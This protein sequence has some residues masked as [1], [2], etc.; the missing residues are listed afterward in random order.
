MKP[1]SAFISNSGIDAMRPFASV[2]K[3]SKS[4]LKVLAATPLERYAMLIADNWECCNSRHGRTKDDFAATTVL[5]RQPKEAFCFDEKEPA[6]LRKTLLLCFNPML[7]N[8][9]KLHIA[10]YSFFNYNDNEALHISEKESTQLR[11]ILKIIATEQQHDLDSTSIDLLSHL[12]AAALDNCRRFYTRQFIMRTDANQQTIKALKEII[13]HYYANTNRSF[14]PTP[15]PKTAYIAEQ[16]NLSKQY[17]EDLI[18]HETGQNID[19]HIKQ[20]RVEI[21]EK[22][23]QQTDKNTQTIARQLGFCSQNCLNS[24]IEKTHGISAEV[25]RMAN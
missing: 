10:D 11:N 5:F 14:S 6:R 20:C 8:E 23:L 24:I 3:L 15:Q 1:V 2:D 12:V 4:D 19:Q 16:L 18:H 21:A 17:L 7:C 9:Q 13:E 25:Y 22:W